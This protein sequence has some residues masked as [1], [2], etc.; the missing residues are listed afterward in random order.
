MTETLNA[1][2]NS[3]EDSSAGDAPATTEPT[4]TAP[5]SPS[6]SLTTADHWY[7]GVSGFVIGVVIALALFAAGYIMYN[8]I[9]PEDGMP[10]EIDTE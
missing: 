7:A 1:P 9:F 6:P 5:V 10:I 8:L 3:T 4:P 2:T